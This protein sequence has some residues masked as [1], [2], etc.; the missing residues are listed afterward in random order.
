MPNQ[1]ALIKGSQRE[2]NIKQALAKLETE[3]SADIAKKVKP[4]GYILIK[5]N[6]IT[7]RRQLA[8]TDVKTIQTVINFLRRFYQGKII[9]GEGA[10]IGKTEE[11]W[12][13]YN[14]L[15]LPHKYPNVQLKDLNIDDGVEKEVYSRDLKPLKVKIAKTA[16][17]AP[18]KISVTPMKTHDMVIVTLSIK[19]MTVG[20]LCKGGLRYLNVASRIL[21]RRPF[22]DYKSAIHQGYKA[23]NMNIAKLY[24][25]IT[26]DLAVIDGFVGMERNGPIGGTPVNSQIALVSTNAIAADVVGAY[27]MG[28]D[29]EEIGY[30]YH[31][32]HKYK[33]SLENIKVLGDNINNC[34]IKYRPHDN[35]V[36]MLD[37]R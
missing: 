22:H 30:L 34:R 9:I 25:Y 6:F 29:S 19:N 2:E 1:V 11:G 8:A 14:Y 24:D 5:T 13:N 20:S 33:V 35:Y 3:I 37:W 16:I 23:L 27:L 36:K 18:Y 10:G 26:P 21:L 31:L 4:K 7:T 28:F 15:A 12:R 17:K 32:S